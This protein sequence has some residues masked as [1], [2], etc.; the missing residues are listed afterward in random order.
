MYDS[1]RR[2]PETIGL[3]TAHRA[4]LFFFRK[5]IDNDLFYSGSLKLFLQRGLFLKEKPMP[6]DAKDIQFAELKDMISQLNN[7]VSVLS[8]MIFF[9]PAP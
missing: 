9:I 8:T 7:T 4:L 6:Q 2:I 1:W 3:R 5:G